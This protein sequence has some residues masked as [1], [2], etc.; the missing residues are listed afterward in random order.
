MSRAWQVEETRG[1]EAGF[2]ALDAGGR[3]CP[4][5]SH[6]PRQAHHAAGA[7]QTEPPSATGRAQLAE[8]AA[9]APTA[10]KRQ[11]DAGARTRTAR[12][13]SWRERSRRPRV[14]R[15]R[16]EHA[17]LRGPG[18]SCRGPRGPG[19]PM[20]CGPRILAPTQDRPGR[21][22]RLR[23]GRAGA[24]RGPRA[25]GPRPPQPGRQ[26]AGRQGCT[27]PPARGSHEWGRDH[28]GA[29]CRG[30]GGR[31]AKEGRGTR[32]WAQGGQGGGGGKTRCSGR[33]RAAGRPAVPAGAGSGRQSLGR[34][35]SRF[36]RVASSCEAG[37][38][39]C[40]CAGRVC[41][42]TGTSE[43][44]TS[45]AGAAAAPASVP[46]SRRRRPACPFPTGDGCWGAAHGPPQRLHG[47]AARLQRHA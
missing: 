21:G 47:R 28:R 17:E 46:V 2:G 7:A 14:E 38:S 43:R 45:Q 41:A 5:P 11:G 30:V 12:E 33:T 36:G 25:H 3:V 13:G 9:P 8:A 32:G 16:P 4:G 22:R 10:R 26:R 37:P 31:R 19:V 24:P 42:P 35:Q 27:R 15:A 6:D 34:R 20:G 40:M 23:G 44:R 1:R 29:D 39:R 18:S